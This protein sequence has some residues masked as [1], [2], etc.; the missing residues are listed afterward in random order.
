MPRSLKG[1]TPIRKSRS[2]RSPSKGRLEE[3]VAEAILDAY[4]ESEQRIGF[5][6][7]I[8]DKFALPFETSVLGVP[9]R[10]ERVAYTD[11][12]EI[13]A[14]CWR[15]AVR[16]RISILELPLPAPPPAGAEWIEAY[17]HWAR[18]V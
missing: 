4:D 2:R 9:V 12:S 10:V 8:E 11:A 16:Q 3:L 17:R 15:G 5:F 13:V 7:M 1:K 6:T 14:V 18:G